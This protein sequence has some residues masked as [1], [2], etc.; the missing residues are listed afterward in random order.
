MV[1][2]MLAV[3]DRG[4]KREGLIDMETPGSDDAV[5]L[6]ESDHLLFRETSIACSDTVLSVSVC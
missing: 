2:H 3:F 6:Y 1:Y 5:L 4:E